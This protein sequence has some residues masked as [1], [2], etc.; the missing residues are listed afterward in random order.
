MKND[1]ENNVKYI[2]KNMN[3]LE[4][5]QTNKEYIDKMV[6]LLKFQVRS[7]Y[8]Y[9][10]L[11][12]ND[13][14]VKHIDT[15]LKTLNEEEDKINNEINT[16]L[17]ELNFKYKEYI[18]KDNE[19]NIF[20]GLKA[21]LEENLKRN[22][23]QEKDKAEK[24][25]EEKKVLIEDK[26]KQLKSEKESIEDIKEQI[27]SPKNLIE[28]K[29]N[30]EFD[31]ESYNNNYKKIIND[32]AITILGKEINTENSSKLFS[33]EDDNYVPNHDLLLDYFE[34]GRDPELVF[35]LTNFYNDLKVI[36]ENKNI[37]EKK[38]E[39]FSQSLYK[40]EDIKEALNDSSVINKVEDALLKIHNLFNQLKNLHLQKIKNALNTIGYKNQKS[41]F[42]IF[43]KFI[44]RNNESDFLLE[45]E[46]N[47]NTLFNSLIEEYNYLKN[48]SKN[49]EI[50]NNDKIGL[51][52]EFYLMLANLKIDNEDVKSNL[53]DIPEIFDDLDNNSLSEIGLIY[54]FIDKYDFDKIHDFINE[55]IDLK[56]D[57]VHNSYK[58]NLKD[59]TEYKNREEELLSK[60]SDKA[61]DYYY[62]FSSEFSLSY[63]ND[64]SSNTFS[65]LIASL[66]LE[67]IFYIDDVKT[68]EDLKNF[69]IRLSDDEI[70]DYKEL[71]T[72]TILPN[73]ENFLNNSM[74]I[75]LV[76]NSQD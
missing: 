63:F 23:E 49:D 62:K 52:F 40:R 37:A 71:I 50:Q 44:K 16:V 54:T 45:N 28:I 48:I 55:I 27:V 13:K 3:D 60:L 18:P 57:E 74:N 33:F 65:P 20:P 46:K 41:K 56:V 69:G 9:S 26:L 8:I 32:C 51:V 6:E 67:T 66:I 36:K 64:L 11:T 38:D 73:I 39:K 15:V 12:E 61:K 34:V 76:N 10:S 35:E 30:E 31:T 70:K 25:F 68:P 72:N 43:D 21:K 4:L 2:L 53:D 47:E 22:Y 75:I 1:I 17:D 42:G 14:L 58:E 19:D 24:D 7:N 29:L 59:L 5:S